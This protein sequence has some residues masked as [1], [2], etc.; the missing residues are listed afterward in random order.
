M[1]ASRTGSAEPRSGAKLTAAV[2]A[3]A[4]VI[5]GGSTA[6][7]ADR[8]SAT[9]SV[10]DAVLAD[11]AAATYQAT[12]AV[13]LDGAP[14]E[15]VEMRV[16]QDPPRRRVDLIVDGS[17]TVQRIAVF[18][19]ERSAVQCTWD[20][21]SWTCEDGAV[22]AGLPPQQLLD[23]FLTALRHPASD[24]QEDGIVASG[25]EARCYQ[26]PRS[27]DRTCVTEDGILVAADS[28]GNRLGFPHL[29]RTVDDAVFDLPSGSMDSAG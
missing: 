27:D 14:G 1:P 7:L 12:Y 22:A 6:V 3:L 16:A 18:E 25:V 26:P 17:G 8:G 13:E 11:A 9:D 23:R 4:V 24:Q 5:A 29:Q 2:T 28:S 10:A 21:R 20:E 15:R 19:F